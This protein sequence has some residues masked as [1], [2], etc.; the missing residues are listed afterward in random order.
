ANM[1]RTESSDANFSFFEN[2]YGGDYLI[3]QSDW[4]EE[5]IAYCKK[6]N[7][8]NF[9]ISHYKG[10]YFDTV[11]FL[12]RVKA[13]RIMIN[14]FGIKSFEAIKKQTELEFLAIDSDPLN[15]QLDFAIFP[16]IEGFKGEWSKNLKNLF[17]RKRL[18]V[19]W[20]WKYKS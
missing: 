6:N 2:E 18:K 5:Q 17:D 20:L 10:F 4:I 11:D 12:D 8:E 13:R 19:L 16:N 1:V 9:F 3:D 7:I 15:D 14:M